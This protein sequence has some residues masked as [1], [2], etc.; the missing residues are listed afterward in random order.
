MKKIGILSDTHGMLDERVFEHFA[1]C[2]EVWH[3][4][5]I[6]SLEVLNKLQAF[7]PLR[8]VWGNID[9]HDI[10][11]LLP[12]HNRF[13]CEGVKV[14]LTHIGGYPGKYD[15]LVRPEIFRQPPDLFVCGHSH[16]LKVQY[17][18]MLKLLHINPGA[19]GKY[20]FHKVQTLI[21]FVIDG[22]KIQNLEVIELKTREPGEK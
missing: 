11:I 3:A 15:A 13:M 18:K 1:L 14:W 10:R 21:R 19:A 20:G 8:A 6:G 17:D 16:I 9:G 2:D 4:G 12:Q 5:D 22:E 7:K